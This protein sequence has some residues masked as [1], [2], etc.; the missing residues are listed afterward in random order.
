MTSKE[1]KYVGSLSP[2]DLEQ[3]YTKL[4]LADGTQLPD[5]YSLSDGW[6][7]DMEKLPPIKWWHITDY[8]MKNPN[9]F[10]QDANK[11]YKSNEAYEFFINGHVQ[12]IY[13]NCISKKSQFSF[14]KSEV[15]QFPFRAHSQVQ[16]PEIQDFRP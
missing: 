8:V 10:T 12:D 5:P 7:Q 2:S 16:Y 4:L 1:A 3:Y 11:N 14:F 6:H 13:M 15:C 9:K